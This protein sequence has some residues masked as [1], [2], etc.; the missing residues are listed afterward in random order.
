MRTLILLLFILTGL[1]GRSQSV[2]FGNIIR[3]NPNDT[4]LGKLTIYK[5]LDDSTYLF[6][7]K[8]FRNQS[9]VSL[10]TGEYIFQFQFKD[11]EFIERLTIHDEESIVIYNI[12]EKPMSLDVFKFK[13]AIFLSSEIVELATRNRKFVYVDFDF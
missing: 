11:R 2:V 13:D 7:E 1:I 12:L 8:Q 4:I 5:A 9:M 6:R 10:D 3:E